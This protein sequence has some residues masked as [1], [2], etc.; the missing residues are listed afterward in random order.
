MPRPRVAVEHARRLVRL[1]KAQTVILAGL[2]VFLSAPSGTSAIPST[3]PTSYPTCRA[4]EV[5]DW[6]TYS[7]ARVDVEHSLRYTDFSGA[8]RT[9]TYTTTWRIMPEDGLIRLQYEEQFCVL[10]QPEDAASLAS[11]LRLLAGAPFGESLTRYGRT[12]SAS[13]ATVSERDMM[14]ILTLESGDVVI[15]V[16]LPVGQM[17][18]LAAAIERALDPMVGQPGAHETGREGAEPTSR[19]DALRIVLDAQSFRSAFADDDRLLYITEWQC[20]GVGKVW[21]VVTGRLLTENGAL[22]VDRLYH[23]VDQDSGRLYLYSN[24]EGILLPLDHDDPA[25]SCH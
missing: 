6:E 20:S 12:W 1:L 25:F 23:A 14:G 16:N 15:S 13:I 10:L 24:A 3:A 18:K 19:Y 2:V 4:L 22:L 11:A 17:A 21:L 5:I 7:R 9:I 8:E